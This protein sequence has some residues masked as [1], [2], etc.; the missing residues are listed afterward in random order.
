MYKLGQYTPFFR[1]IQFPL[2]I[3]C[4][5]AVIATTHD[6]VQIAVSANEGCI[7]PTGVPGGQQITI[8]LCPAGSGAAGYTFNLGD[9]NTLQSVNYSGGDTGGGNVTITYSYTTANTL[10]IVET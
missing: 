9:K 5:I 10:S 7:A 1:S 2:E 6:G 3:T 8:V 4:E